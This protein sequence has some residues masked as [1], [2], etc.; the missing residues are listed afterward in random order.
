M[1]YSLRQL[2][3]IFLESL[4]SIEYFFSDFPAYKNS[5]L[6]NHRKHPWKITSVNNN[7]YLQL[8]EATFQSC[9]FVK[10]LWKYATTN[11]LENTHAEVW[12][13]LKL[14][15]GFIEISLRHEY[16]HTWA[17][18]FSE[19]LVLGTPLEGCFWTVQKILKNSYSENFLKC[20]ISGLRFDLFL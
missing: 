15:C 17:W 14:P 16:F 4:F 9:S 12:F 7:S 3:F 13:Q 10:V 20:P 6:P 1:S 8:S 18:V 5:Y 2:V 11:L 19:Y